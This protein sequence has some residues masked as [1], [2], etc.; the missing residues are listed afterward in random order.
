MKNLIDPKNSRGERGI[1][2]IVVM[3]VVATLTILILEFVHSTRINL[4]IAG[5]IADGMKASYLSGSGVKVAAGAMLDDLQDNKED[6]LYEDWA[7]ALPA[8]PGGEGWVTVTITDEAS[9][10]NINRLVRKS[11][12]ADTVR[13][14]VFKRLMLNLELDPELSSAIIDWIDENPEGLNGGDESSLYGYASLP[15]PYPAKNG[16]LL[17]VNELTM[18]NGITDEV[19]Q[20]IKPYVTIYGDKKLNLNTVDEKVLSAYVQVL[21]GE[22]DTKPAQDIITWRETDENYFKDKNLKKTLTGDVGIESALAS[23]L[24]KYFGGSS[25]YFSVSTEAVVGDAIKRALGVIQRGKQGVKII[26]FRPL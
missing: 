25:R 18:I 23:K 8:I 26:Y 5:N 21:S 1:A 10:F 16:P 2:L 15:D 9:K 17:S 20:K 3:F 4:Y 19:Y 24:A 14:D 7:Q 11:G 6:H 22:D 13:L 12:M